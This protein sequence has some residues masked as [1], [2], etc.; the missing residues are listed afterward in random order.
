MVA[1]LKAQFLKAVVEFSERRGFE[2]LVGV[3]V[4]TL[5]IDGFRRIEEAQEEVGVHLVVGR[6]CLLVCVDLAEQQR[7]QEAPD[8][9]DRMKVLHR[10]AQGKRGEHVTVNI[11]IAHEI[12]LA[13]ATFIEAGQCAQCLGVLEG[14]RKAR[15][16]LSE[17]LNRAVGK[18]HLERYG[19]VV[20]PV[21]VPAE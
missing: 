21:C 17:T 2:R 3:L 20:E 18:R 9:G 16:G 12:G 15:R 19:G 13:D 8:R 7:L 6:D 4:H 14:D 1:G 5:R 11:E 10:P